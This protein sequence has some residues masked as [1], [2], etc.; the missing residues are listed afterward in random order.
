MVPYNGFEA[1]RHE[2]LGLNKHLWHKF[3]VVVTCFNVYQLVQLKKGPL[4]IVDLE[5][6]TRPIVPKDLVVFRHLLW[7]LL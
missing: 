3:D 7:R 4:G 5:S 1:F 2:F 6:V